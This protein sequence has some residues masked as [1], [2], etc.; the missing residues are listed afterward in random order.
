MFFLQH[1]T[2]SAIMSGRLEYEKVAIQAAA[3]TRQKWKETEGMC[4]YSV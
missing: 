3:E 2:E 1:P 4:S